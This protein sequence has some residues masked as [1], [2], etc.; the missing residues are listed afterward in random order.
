M[1]LQGTSYNEEE[2]DKKPVPK[3]RPAFPFLKRKTQGGSDFEQKKKKQ[4][5]FFLGILLLFLGRCV[6][7]CDRAGERAESAVL[8]RRHA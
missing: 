7:D 4:D 8:Q 2:A 1:I 6:R 5:R 3:E